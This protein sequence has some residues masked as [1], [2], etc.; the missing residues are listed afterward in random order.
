MAKLIEQLLKKI[1][2]KIFIMDRNII[3]IGGGTI[4]NN[5]AKFI[6]TQDVSLTYLEFKSINSISSESFCSQL[7]INFHC[8]NKIELTDF[9]MKLNQETIIISASNR[10]LFPE[11]VLA[12]PN[13]FIINFHGSF[14]PEFPGRNTEA[15]AI[16]KQSDYGGITWHK[17]E[18][19]VDKGDIIIQKK[20]P[21]TEKHTSFTLLREYM[22][23][24]LEAFMEIFETLISGKILLTP[25]ETSQKH[26]FN[27]SNEIPNNGY[28][29]LSWN[30]TQMSSFL[31]AMDYGPLVILGL[32]MILVNETCYKI[33][34]YSIEANQNIDEFVNFDIENN[35]VTI[36]R[37][38]LVFKLDRLKVYNER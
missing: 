36:C 9:F 23:K 34:K 6:I 27:F 1:T 32:P 20:I 31:R 13:L 24:G 11:M 18:K 7:G 17:V 26:K 2:I 35:K 38:N 10:Y 21:I 3:I 15:W 16:F 19:E 33:Q 8:L 30:G 25:Q 4:A 37:D 29:D 12:K 22:N 28:L 14:L 5:I